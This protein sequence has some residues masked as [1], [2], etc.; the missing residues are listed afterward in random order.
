[1][2]EAGLALVST[3]DGVESRGRVV[4]VEEE[5]TERTSDIANKTDKNIYSPNVVC[6][7]LLK[8]V[9]SAADS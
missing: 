1:M 2:N 9:E 7:A 3:N 5:T 8:E 6:P 4:L